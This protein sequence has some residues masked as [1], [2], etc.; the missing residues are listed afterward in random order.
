MVTM[1]IFSDAS[2]TT[3]FDMAAVKTGNS[4]NS[5][6]IIDRVAIPKATPM[7][8]G[9]CFSVITMITFPDASF[10]RK[11]NIATVKTGSGYK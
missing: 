7:F 4:Y 6:M 8:M 1:T 9:I 5:G 3:K 2:F 10:T 11:F